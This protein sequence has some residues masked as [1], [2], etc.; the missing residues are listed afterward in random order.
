MNLF[1]P[2]RVFLREAR[3]EGDKEGER[4]ICR[5]M[6]GLFFHSLI[7][8]L[9]RQL[10]VIDKLSR[11]ECGKNCMRWQSTRL[12]RCSRQKQLLS[13]LPSVQ[14]VSRISLATFRDSARSRIEATG[15]PSFLL[16]AGLELVLIVV[17]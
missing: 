6:E 8:R 16:A 10:L 17:G 2:T 11:A 3:R 5:Q 7:T 4:V 1:F 13:P 15:P 14:N 9:C 12:G